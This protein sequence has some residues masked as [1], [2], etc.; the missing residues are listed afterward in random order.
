MEEKI[1]ICTKE[2]PWSPDKSRRAMH[3]DAKHTDSVDYGLG[4]Y[5]EC[6]K[7]PYCG[8]YF[9]VELPQ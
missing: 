3:P 5:C 8:K 6:Y 9:E 4:E 2:D 1:H 7:C